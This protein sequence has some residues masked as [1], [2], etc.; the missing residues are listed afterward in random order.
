MKRAVLLIAIALTVVLYVH[1]QIPDPGDPV[2][3]YCEV[4]LKSQQPHKPG[5]PYYSEPQEE[6]SSSSSSSSSSSTSSKPSRPFNER[7]DVNL[8]E[9]GR[10]RYRCPECGNL[11]HTGSCQLGKV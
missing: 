2:C 1:A 6:E 11:H 5:C 7:T 3:V 10:G 8:D 9:Y 4:D